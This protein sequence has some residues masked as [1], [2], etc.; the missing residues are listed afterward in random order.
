MTRPDGREIERWA[1]FDEAVANP[2]WSS[3]SD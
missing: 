2:R 1:S 3:I